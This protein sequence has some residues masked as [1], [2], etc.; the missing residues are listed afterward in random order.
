MI[1]CSTYL[2]PFLAYFTKL[3][4]TV[5]FVILQMYQVSLHSHLPFL[6][7]SVLATLPLC[8]HMF[9]H[10]PGLLSSHSALLFLCSTQHNYK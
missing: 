3:H 9:H 6:F 4:P 2:V 1:Y 7:L 5:L 10:R 8:L